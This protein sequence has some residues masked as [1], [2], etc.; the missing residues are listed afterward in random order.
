MKAIVIHQYGDSSEFKHVEISMPKPT[1][2][3]VLVKVAGTSINPIDTKIRKGIVPN[4]FQPN[5]PMILHSD[6]SGEVVEVGE[7]VSQFEVGDLVFGLNVFSGTLTDYFLIE[8]SFIAKAPK[9]LPIQEAASLPLTSITAWEALFDRG[10][11]KQG[12]HILIHGGTGGVGHVA[13][14][15]AKAFGA[16]VTTTVSSNEKADLVKKLGVDHVINYKEESVEEYVNRLTNGQGFD[17]VFDT[18][19]QKNLDKS[20]LAVKPKGTV[21][22]IAARSTHDL[23][24]LHNKSLSLHV[25]FIMLTQKTKEG[26]M[27]HSAI[28]NKISSLVEE[29]KLKPLINP[30]SFTFN[31]V[32]EAHDYFENNEVQFGKLLIENK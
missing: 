12:D 13:I 15:L 28:L 16:I 32:K 21:L 5:F 23:T 4:A 19:G 14:Q 22:A 31:Q 17:L 10:N 18:V 27:E 6:F 29:G 1:G 26:R 7:N 8:E 11:L 3:Q 25:I 2:N 9:N 20:F 30:K 24:L